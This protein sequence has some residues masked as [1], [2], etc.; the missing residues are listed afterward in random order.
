MS[1][2]T[3]AV[4]AS[5]KRASSRGRRRMPENT[6]HAMALLGGW[7]GALLGQQLFRHKRR[8]LTFQAITWLI[9]AGHLAAWVWAWAWRH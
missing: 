8:K 9:A 6:L 1:I 4:Y 7:P 3:L 5:D 2:V